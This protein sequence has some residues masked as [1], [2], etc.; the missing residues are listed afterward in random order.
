MNKETYLNIAL[1]K[2]DFSIYKKSLFPIKTIDISDEFQ[3]FSDFIIRKLDSNIF[4]MNSTYGPKENPFKPWDEILEIDTIGTNHQLILNKY[5]VQ[6]GHILLITRNWKPQNGWL[7]KEDWSAMKKVNNDTSGLWFFNSSKEAGASQP[8]RHI[9]LLPRKATEKKCPRY[10]WFENLINIKYK[11]SKLTK[12][13]FVERFDFN[14][15]IDNI[16]NQYLEISRKI[17][18]G[19]PPIDK[20]PIKPYNI[21]LTD[22]WIAIIKRSKDNIYGYSVN[23]LGFAG[24]LL[25]TKLS[26][27]SYLKK[28]GPEKLLENFV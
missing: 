18:L 27:I 12:N 25:V 21:V 11:K 6:T 14:E 9:Q 28:N 2:T 22:K 19:N 24:Y 1:K 20:K 7:E 3:N 13:I 8:H 5:P 23:G 4:R 16:Y 26:D 15:S 17:G 10:D